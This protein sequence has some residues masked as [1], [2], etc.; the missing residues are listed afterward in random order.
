MCI[1][2]L[3]G[4]HKKSLLMLDTVW[5]IIKYVYSIFNRL[6]VYDDEW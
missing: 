4:N 1:I 6:V 2:Y 5:I 3:D